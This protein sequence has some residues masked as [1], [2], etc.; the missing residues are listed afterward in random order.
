MAEIFNIEARKVIKMHIVFVTS[1][2]PTT[3]NY[4]GGLAS[5]TVNIAQI[6]KDH[7]NKV[8]I[9]YVTTKDTDVECDCSVE[10]RNIYIAKSDWDTY[11]AV[12]KIYFENEE[13]A[14]INRR[15]ILKIIKA[16]EVRYEIERI[17][18][19]NRIDIV[20]F[21]NHGAFSMLMKDDIPYV[22]RI[23]GFLN[24]YHGGGSVPNGS[25]EY[26]DNPL[27]IDDKIETYA[28]KRAQRVFAPSKLIANIC[29]KNLCINADILES[30]F[31]IETEKMDYAKY[32]LYGLKDKKYIIFYGNLRYLKGIQVIADLIE[33]FLDKWRDRYFVLAGV[34]ME[35]HDDNGEHIQ[36]SAYV[37]SKAGRYGDRVIYT[38][39]L[40]KSELYPLISNSELCL[41]PSRIENLSNACIE[42]M[43][44]GKI[45]VAT[46][47]ASYEQII[48]NGQSGFLCTRDDADSFFQGIE[49]V[50]TLPLNQRRI[51]E[52]NAQNAVK[53]LQP[54]SV[55]EN[56]KN[57]YEDVILKWRRTYV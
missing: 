23:S 49:K 32:E 2:L 15:E 37:K 36:A 1:E 29:L 44:L 40:R 35:I 17:N 7:G 25:L 20:H 33:K 30:P 19:E 52:Q 53:R 31:L 34:D 8:E 5:F 28:L 24:I 57:Y 56:F 48:Q 27:S 43:A 12:S 46:D 42:A 21:S 9:I 45:V 14:I 39:K 38:G 41:F 10:I 26:D 47:G 54:E 50:L 22:I 3:E 51:I 55:Y 6:F 18:N 4:G 13:N 16:K 11:D